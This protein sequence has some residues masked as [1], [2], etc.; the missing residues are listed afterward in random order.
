MASVKGRPD[1]IV[2]PAAAG[3]QAKL[4]AALTVLADALQVARTR[5]ATAAD[6]AEPVDAAMAE[7]LADI[8][9][10]LQAMGLGVDE[11]LAELPPASNRP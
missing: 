10:Q 8:Y 4:R 6:K 1:E 9:R 2:S 7:Q 5:C 11:S 3:A